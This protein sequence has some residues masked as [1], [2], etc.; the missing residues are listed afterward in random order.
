MQPLPKKFHIEVKLANFSSSWNAAANRT[1]QKG[2][3]GIQFG[4]FI[5]SPEQIYY[6]KVPFGGK[7]APVSQILI[8]GKNFS[9]PT[10]DVHFHGIV[11]SYSAPETLNPSLIKKKKPEITPS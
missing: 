9:P 8:E 4:K 7:N 6:W 1:V 5:P 3:K 10:F 2:N 11:P